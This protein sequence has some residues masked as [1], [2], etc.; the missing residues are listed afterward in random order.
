MVVLTSGIL[1][2]HCYCHRGSSHFQSWQTWH[3]AFFGSLINAERNELAGTDSQWPTLPLYYV[4]AFFWHFI[5]RKF[6]PWNMNNEGLNSLD[7]RTTQRGKL[8]LKCQHCCK[9]REDQFSILAILIII[10]FNNDWLLFLPSELRYNIRS[11]YTPFW[12]SCQ[13]THFQNRYHQQA[14]IHHQRW[15]KL[16]ASLLCIIIF[17]ASIIFQGCQ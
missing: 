17:S 15:R 3:T 5:P 7:I 1:Y 4:F 2:H 11:A 16:A 9:S 6:S 10:A 12:N 13:N 8:Q 14:I